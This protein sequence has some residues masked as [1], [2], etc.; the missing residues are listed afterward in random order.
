VQELRNVNSIRKETVATAAEGTKKT[1]LAKT[2][3]TKTSGKQRGIFLGLTVIIV[4]V[5]YSA[6]STSG[7][8]SYKEA[9]TLYKNKEFANSFAYYKNAAEKG[10]VKAQLKLSN[11]YATGTGVAKNDVESSYWLKLA[12]KQRNDMAMLTLGVN[13]SRGVGVEKDEKEAFYWLMQT[14]KKEGSGIAQTTSQLLVGTFY[15]EGRAVEKNY[16]EAMKYLKLAALA[17]PILPEAMHNIGVLYNEGRGVK[18][19]N[20]KAL[21]WLNISARSGYQRSQNLRAKITKTMTPQE[22]EAAENLA[23]QCEAQKFKSCDS[24]ITKVSTS[25][26]TN[27][28]TATPA[29]T[30]N[31][32]SRLEINEN[33][34]LKITGISENMAQGIARTFK[35]SYQ[36]VSFLNASMEKNLFDKFECVVNV[37]TGVGPK[38]C[39]INNT[40]E[41]FGGGIITNNTKTWAH[42]GDQAT[43]C[44]N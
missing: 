10:H 28:T 32:N 22:V 23:T 13:Y 3:W 30:A 15:I 20:I 43:Y 40:I 8:Q 12:A 17:G 5:L 19:D 18:V 11:M 36:T 2:F 16:V 41:F 37:D 33:N 27:N 1:E 14:A 34:C 39:L 44:S 25:A 24:L 35:V 38:K 26:K 42:M 29:S 7:E 21:M 9:E 6:L 31:T 4:F